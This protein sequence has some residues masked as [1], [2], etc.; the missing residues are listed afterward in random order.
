MT[1][2]IPGEAALLIV[3]F[4]PQHVAEQAFIQNKA[5]SLFAG[6]PPVM[7]L[8]AGPSRLVFK[9]HD[10]RNEWPLTMDTLMD[11]QAYE[12]VLSANALP[13][14]ATSGP[15]IK[16]PVPLE[17]ALEVP[18]GLYLS[19]DRFGTWYHSI[20]PVGSEGRFELWH[21]RLGA[22]RPK[23]P[24]ADTKDTNDT[25]VYS[26]VI[27]TTDV[28]FPFKTSLNAGGNDTLTDIARLSSDFS[29]PRMPGTNGL[30]NWLQ[31]PIDRL[32]I[33][34]WQKRLADKGLPLKYVP[35]PVRV[36]RLMLSSAGAWAN[37]ESAWDY[38]TIIKGVN[39]GLGYDP[40]SLEQWQH[41]AAQGRDQYVKTVRKGY[42]CDTGHRVS[43][44]TITRR[45]FQP[46][47]IRT[48]HT[49]DGNIGIFGSIAYLRQYE[50]IEV[51]EPIK[52]YTPLA[53]AYAHN[54]REMP[55]KTIRI[56]TRATPML[57]PHPEGLFWPMV[58]GKPFLFQMVA[59]DAEGK[60]V[61][62]ERP[63]LFVPLTVQQRTISRFPFFRVIVKDTFID[64]HD[65]KLEYEKSHYLDYKTVPL[66][67][68]SVAFA[69]TTT[70][71]KGKTSLSA[72]N[73]TFT[74]QLVDDAGK[75]G[76]LT[77]GQPPFLPEVTAASVRIPS[78]ER[79]LG[80]SLPVDIKLAEDY[81]TGGMD[82]QNNRGELFAELPTSL[83]LPIPP[84]LTGGLV[85]PDMSIAGLSRL[86]GPV[87]KLDQFRNNKLDTSMFDKASFLGGITLK[88]ILIEAGSLD[89][90]HFEHADL[91]VEDLLAKLDKPSFK[92][93]I[94]L[95]T[96]REIYPPGVDPKKPTAPPIAV[97][98]RFLWKP[99]I[100]DHTIGPFQFQPEAALGQLILRTILVTPLNGDPLTFEV[101][102]Q[103]KKF[104]LAFANALNLDFES[105]SFR[106]VDGKKA[107]V[108]VEGLALTFTGPLKFVDT[109]KNIIPSNGFS[110]PPFLDVTA[111]GIR[112]G[113]TLSV[114]TVN[115]GIFSLQNLSLGA[116]LTL[117][118][119]NQPA[120]IRFNISEREKPFLVTVGLF[121]GSG[122]FALSLNAHGIEQIEAAIEFGGNVSLDLGVASGGI[123]V[124]AG[125]YFGMDK[126]NVMLTGYLRCGG[127]LSVLGLISLSVEFYLG[128]SYLD[129]GNEK[130]EVWGQATVT[131]CI[132]I[133]FFSKS[134][135][136]K[137]ERR[138]AGAAGDPT[139]GQLVSPS[140]WENYCEAFA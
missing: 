114:P 38:P 108:S 39:D 20:Q 111:S 99:D 101:Y 117:P 58:G 13:F 40:L 131:V 17:T 24:G 136:L 119:V 97:E 138:F 27:G 140:E 128:F 130:G 36:R 75:L 18:T 49:Q 15:G 77:N 16:K 37:L 34:N 98:T 59:E 104:K 83:A 35:S 76:K 118:F 113:Y 56:T 121:G 66:H 44:V 133:A 23:E 9:L 134:V 29:M 33:R 112:A 102:G 14:E 93:K 139:F 109:L 19:P 80:R 100:R 63:L 88:D 42:L 52:D 60:T 8:L 28:Q 95:L 69:E 127:Y 89:L 1:R 96:S 103:L 25:P 51:Q 61:H 74:M 94:P 62:M 105:L 81:L 30:P 120:G 78:V 124:M 72:E 73:I 84:E 122:F 10:D 57:D 11:W 135:E 67:A 53:W 92:L 22:A 137:V 50:Y 3:H 110:D 106:S 43:I 65:V 7:A 129:K 5:G 26:R 107:D 41:I 31:R 45:E 6:P 55:F 85:K 4:P 90:D 32:I 2:I 47:Q 54:G 86:L 79:L 21:T 116:A 132:D 68:Q 46:Y 123:S 64:W 91:P 125:I 12:P 71:G 115:V 48:E 70:E 82:P 87:D 126:D